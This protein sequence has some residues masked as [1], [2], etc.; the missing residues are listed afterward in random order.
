MSRDE[1]IAV[2]LHHVQDVA[3]VLEPAPLLVEE[4]RDRLVA[5]VPWMKWRHRS[6]RSTS[7]LRKWVEQEMQGS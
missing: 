6:Q 5:S 7:S 2:A 1:M 3:L 4:L